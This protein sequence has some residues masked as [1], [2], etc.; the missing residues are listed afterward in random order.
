MREGREGAG[1]GRKKRGLAG[2]VETKETIK[3]ERTRAVTR[4]EREG[5]QGG[6]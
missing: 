1:R 5:V 3:K 4:P 2:T 6:G